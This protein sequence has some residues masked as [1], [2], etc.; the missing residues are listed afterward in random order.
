MKIFSDTFRP[1]LKSSCAFRSLFPGLISAVI[2][3]Y[4]LEADE[5]KKTARRKKSDL[6]L[7]DRKRFLRYKRFS[8]RDKSFFFFE[9]R[10]ENFFLP[11][12]R[13]SRDNLSG[14][15]ECAIW[16]SVCM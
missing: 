11:V 10:E 15:P 2:A 5:G 9:G 3:A 8:P 7:R 6:K 4:E 12:K 16:C 14:E 13:Y 1:P